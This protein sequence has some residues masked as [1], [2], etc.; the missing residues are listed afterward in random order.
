[1]SGEEK[2]GAVMA[3]GRQEDVLLGADF[4]QEVVW[5]LNEDARPVAGVYLAAA[6]APVL[7]ILER[8]DAVPHDLVRLFAVQ[9]HDKANA[10]GVVFVLRVV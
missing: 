1:M 10:A 7:Q 3:F 8:D 4:A 2:A 5:D 9:P 6:G